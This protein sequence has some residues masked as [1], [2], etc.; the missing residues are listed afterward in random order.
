MN[1]TFPM[2][3]LALIYK[4]LLFVFEQFQRPIIQDRTKIFNT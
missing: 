2:H 1:N 4:Y 3:I